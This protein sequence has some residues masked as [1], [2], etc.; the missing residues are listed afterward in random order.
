M[1]LRDT[2]NRLLGRRIEPEVSGL[3][4]IGKKGICP[5]CKGNLWNPGPTGGMSQNIRCAGCGS[6]FCFAGPFTPQRIDNGDEVY[7]TQ[8]AASLKE[9]TG[10]EGYDNFVKTWIR[11]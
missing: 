6:K 8:Y 11:S 9:I 5:D 3:D 1:S 4:L 7:N 2:F 10:W